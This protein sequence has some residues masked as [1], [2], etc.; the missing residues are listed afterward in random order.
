MDVDLDAYISRIQREDDIFAKGQLFHILI[1][2]Y[3]VPIKEIARQLKLSSSYVCNIIRIMKLPD[4]VRDGY[5]SGLVS[6][7]HLF[8]IARLKNEKDIIDLYDMV[9]QQN[10]STSALEE[11][12]RS[13]LYNIS[14]DGEHISEST[15]SNFREALEKIN[16]HLRV[17]IIQSRIR[18]KIVIE[19]DGG[20]KETSPILEKI[21]SQL[22][23]DLL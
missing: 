19:M 8:I 21:A 17:K 3:N 15:K 18:A 20:L 1:D 4:L 9:L 6:P 16:P 14:S 11:L 10:L 7:T 22:K 13:T 2:E 23:N 12:V 5:Y